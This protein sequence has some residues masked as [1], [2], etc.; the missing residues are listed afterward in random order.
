L[1]SALD[2]EAQ[3]AAMLTCSED[4]KEGFMAFVEKRKPVFKG[5]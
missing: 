4:R 5:R 1:S 3:I 2:Y